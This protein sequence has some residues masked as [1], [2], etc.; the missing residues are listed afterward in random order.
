[1]PKITTIL[2][3]IIKGAIPSL[4]ISDSTGVH[5][6]VACTSLLTLKH[7]SKPFP[8]TSLPLSLFRT[9]FLGANRNGTSFDKY[10]L[11]S[12]SISRN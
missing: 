6:Q 9:K 11:N 8:V 12:L 10:C 5:L 2:S 7:S 4:K 1:M 3:V